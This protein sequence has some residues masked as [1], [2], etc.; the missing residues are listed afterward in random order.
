[1]LDLD[2]PL[3]GQQIAEVLAQPTRAPGR[4]ELCGAITQTRPYGPNGEQV[5]LDCAMKD[6][7]AAARGFHKRFGFAPGNHS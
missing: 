7:A 6:Q 4:C 2:C 5:C 1:M 3:H